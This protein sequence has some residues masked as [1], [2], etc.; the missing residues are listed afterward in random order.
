MVVLP[1]S[2]IFLVQH[3]SLLDHFRFILLPSFKIGDVHSVVTAILL[4]ENAATFI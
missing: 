4:P 3:R 2:V 1:L